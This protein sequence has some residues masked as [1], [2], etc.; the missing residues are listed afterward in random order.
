MRYFL[1]IILISFKWLHGWIAVLEEYTLEG[2]QGAWLVLGTSIFLGRGRVC[3]LIDSETQQ[4]CCSAADAKHSLVCTEENLF[5][6]VCYGLI[7]FCFKAEGRGLP[8][9]CKSTHGSTCLC[10][11]TTAPGTI[12]HLWCCFSQPCLPRLIIHLKTVTWLWFHS[13]SPWEVQTSITLI[14]HM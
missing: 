3:H 4:E 5:C 14:F 12:F 7:L 10:A 8:T 11:V 9:V 13:A 1:I 2:S 6:L